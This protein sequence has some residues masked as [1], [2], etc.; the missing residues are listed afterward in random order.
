MAICQVHL[1]LPRQGE[2]LFYEISGYDKTML[3]FL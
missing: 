1:A 3:F 2:A